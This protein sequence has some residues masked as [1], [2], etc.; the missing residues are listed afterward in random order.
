MAKGAT[1]EEIVE[2]TGKA[3]RTIKYKASRESWKYI[4]SPTP[5]G[6]EKQF[7]LSFLPDEIR[8]AVA[9]HRAANTLITSSPA[10][11]AGHTAGTALAKEKAKQSEL[12]RIKREEQLAAFEQ[13]PVKKQAM[14]YARRDVLKARKAYLA[15]SGISNKKK[16]TLLFC[17]LY[18][19][20]EI[21]INDTIRSHVP[22]VSS[23][24]LNR[25]QSALKN[26]GVP[27]LA[28]GYCNPK[29]GST[30]LSQEQ[31]DFI[32]GMLAKSPHCTMATMEMAM[33]ARFSSI[34]HISTIRRFTKRWKTENASI[35]LFITNPDAWRNKH[36]FALGDASAQVERLNQVWEFD[37]TPAD[38]M[39]AD[40][41]Y[42]LIGVIDVFSRRLK[43]LVSKTS[44]S[45]A[46]AALTRRAVLDWG[47]PEIAKTDN[48]ADYVSHHMVQVF[49]GLEI[50]Q[51]LCPPFTPENKPHIERAFKTFAHSFMELMPG[52]IGHSVA[53]RK[54]IEARRSFASR[55]M[56]KDSEVEIKMTAEELQIH[57]DRWCEAIYHQNKHKGLDNMTPA[58]VARIWPKAVRTVSNVRALDILLAEA[59][60]SGGTR[61]VAKDG[62]K[63]GRVFYI[64]DSLPETGTTVR[65]KLDKTDLGTIYLF[66]VDGKFLCVAQDPQRT[67]I[68]RAETA[69]TIKNRQ[70]KLMREGSK[71]LRKLTREQA[72]DEINEEILEY[73]EDKIANI[74]EL[75]KRR[76]EYTTTA[77]DEAALAVN[78]LDKSNRELTE[79]DEIISD[80]DIQ[81]RQAVEIAIAEHETDKAKRKR[82]GITHIFTSDSDQ[83]QWIRDRERKT[84]GLTTPELDF[85][86]RYYTTATGSFYLRNEG[87]LRKKIGLRSEQER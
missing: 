37:S 63:V 41:R 12:E 46:V 67:G 54:D 47:I 78:A 62:V 70:K 56:N 69:S 28:P 38:V 85:L 3:I 1:F 73:R 84:P 42:C 32:I 48:G 52:Y 83:Y 29:K 30:G 60:G 40:G 26:K 31:Q 7:T 72:L 35:F 15:A 71:E 16:G 66:D 18:N 57:C 25:W 8:L 77:L 80:C 36:Q 27:G 58:E 5:T 19:G 23:S 82:S 65:V 39:L 33:E 61:V 87:D 10:A 86:N 2:A 9:K 14:A 53:D 13:I 22:K 55:I 79:I 45:T 68:D 49:E 34:P 6:H 64:S 11:Q 4:Y 21:N 59:P 76:E 20:G 43:L 44:R 17:Q 74:I 50:E 24:T 75:P 81:E 51:K